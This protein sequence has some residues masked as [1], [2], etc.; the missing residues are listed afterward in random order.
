VRRRR[1]VV[2]NKMGAT[3][4]GETRVGVRNYKKRENL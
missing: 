3:K 2:R 4:F 1:K